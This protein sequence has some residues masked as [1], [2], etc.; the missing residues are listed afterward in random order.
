MAL[1]LAAEAPRFSCVTTDTVL[2]A[3]RR[4]TESVWSRDPSLTTMIS[5]F[6]HVCPSA[7]WMVSAIHGSALYAGIRIETRGGMSKVGGQRSEIR[8]LCRSVKL[9]NR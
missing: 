4:A 2:E 3:N 8:G 5:L 1:F 6:G 9:V 7:D